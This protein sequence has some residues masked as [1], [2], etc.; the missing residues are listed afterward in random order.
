[1]LTEN[2]K[3]RLLVINVACVNKVLIKIWDLFEKN[4]Y[5]KVKVSDFKNFMKN[6]YRTIIPHTTEKNLDFLV[7]EEV[8]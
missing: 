8:Y 1:M 3:R 6:A 7:D 4:F 5:A 2:S